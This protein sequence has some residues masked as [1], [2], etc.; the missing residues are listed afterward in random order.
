MKKRMEDMRNIAL[1]LGAGAV[2]ALG[3]GLALVAT[4]KT[5]APTVP[6]MRLVPAVPSLQPASQPIVYIDGVR[7][8]RSVEGQS[9]L[10]L[11]PSGLRG[12]LDLDP[13]QIDRVEVIKGSAAKQMYG[14]EGEHGVIQIFTKPSGESGKS[15]ASEGSVERAK[16]DSGSGR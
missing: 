6:A 8:N 3:T 11:S 1:I 9:P 13:D 14:S 7:V 12:G 2:G 4:Q 16:D 15:E 10:R 5:A